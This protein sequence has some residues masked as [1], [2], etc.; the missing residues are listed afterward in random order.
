MY[1]LQSHGS[2]GKLSRNHN[3]PEI[4]NNDKNNVFSYTK[5]KRNKNKQTRSKYD[6]NQ[7]KGGG[8]GGDVYAEKRWASFIYFIVDNKIVLSSM[9]LSAYKY[10]SGRFP[11]W[12]R[13][14]LCI[15]SI[16]LV[17]KFAGTFK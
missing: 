3:E 12:F 7:N 11:R 4:Y 10:N 15:I 5:Y 17:A 13:L 1:K 6:C 8:G 9:K 2:S 16:T 14:F